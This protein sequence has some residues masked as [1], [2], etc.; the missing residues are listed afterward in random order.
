MT[1]KYR[2]PEPKRNMIVMVRK[3]VLF[4]SRIFSHVKTQIKSF[5]IFTIRNFMAELAVVSSTLLKSKNTIKFRINKEKT[6]P[7]MCTTSML[8]N[9]DF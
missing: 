5:A 6:S 3:L 9:N 4:F 1:K 2:I 7:R 8:Q